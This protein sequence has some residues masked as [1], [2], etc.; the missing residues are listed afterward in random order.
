MTDIN[1]GEYLYYMHYARCSHS[2]IFYF[3]LKAF[4]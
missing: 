2:N 1:I 3:I 4:P